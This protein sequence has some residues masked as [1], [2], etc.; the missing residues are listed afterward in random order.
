MSVN[1][2]IQ[3]DTTTNLGSYAKYL[4]NDYYT[5]ISGFTDQ[6]HIVDHTLQQL[7]DHGEALKTFIIAVK[8]YL[9]H[10]TYVLLPYINEL[11]EK[12]DG[13]H[14]CATCSGKCNVQ[15]TAAL[16]DFNVSLLSIKDALYMLKSVISI[17]ESNGVIHSLTALTDIV[18]QVLQLEEDVLQPMIKTAQSHINAVN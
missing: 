18:G 15:H 6:I 1:H 14:N 5:V 17:Y 16:L 7:E 9:E 8:K 2:S 12:Q 11:A 3:T 4:N 13:G 10:R